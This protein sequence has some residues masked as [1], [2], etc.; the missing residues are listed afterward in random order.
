MF[1]GDKMKTKENVILTNMCMVY[2]ENQ[3][4]V[5]NRKSTDWPGITFPGGHIEPHESFVD[6]VIREVKEETNLDI[7]N[8]QLCGIKQF[9]YDDGTRY[10]VIFYKTN[11]FQGTYQSSTEGDVF[12]I[13]KADLH[14]YPLAN[15]FDKMFAVMD[16]DTL[17]EVYYKKEKGQWLPFVK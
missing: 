6:A 10:I 7:K 8:P 3:I 17:S 1:L 13:D 15:D 9:T 14:Q 11:Q 5:L 12:W 4:L 16:S 2:K